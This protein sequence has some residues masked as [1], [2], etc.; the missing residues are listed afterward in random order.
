VADARAGITV[1]PGDAR[2]LADA[3]MALA[4]KPADSL[5]EMGW[6]GRRYVEDRFNISRLTAGLERVL[7]EVVCEYARKNSCSQL[8]IGKKM[9]RVEGKVDIV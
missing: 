6:S 9:E 7:V 2:S 4:K 1:P 8:Q 3:I 5:M